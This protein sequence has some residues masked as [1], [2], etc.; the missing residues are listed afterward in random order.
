M[1]G[2]SL[3]VNAVK[4][5][6]GYLRLPKTEGKPDQALINKMVDKFLSSGGI[7]FDT[8]YVYDG[9]EAALRDTVVKRHPRGSFK[10]ATKLQIDVAGPEMSM[11]DIF[12][13]SLERLGTDYIDSYLIHGINAKSNQKAEKLGAW[14]HLLKLKAQGL[15][16]HMGFSFHGPPEDLDEILQKHPEAEFVQL[17]I[18]YFDWDNPKVQSRRLYE[19]ARA[20]N[21]PIIV[22]EPLLG[23]KLASTDSPAAELFFKADPGAS[24]ASW[25]LRF[26]AG[27]DGVIMV[28]SGMSSYEQMTD[29]IATFTNLSPLTEDE[30]SIIDKAAG[31]LRSV[32]RVGCTQCNYCKDCPSNIHIPM[33]IDIYNDFLIH[34]TMTNLDRFYYLATAGSGKALDCTAC[35]ACE[36]ICPQNL[37]IVD[38][39]TN[40]S[41]MFD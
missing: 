9:A 23:G 5:G 28:L 6:F 39:M 7:Y 1:T 4:L 29:N 32:P 20:H 41:K 35:R 3:S 19:T 11:D 34:K 12:N 16:G 40:I 22:M 17:Q 38:T 37:E 26:A 8:A 36:R 2:L 31:I 30:R 25:G 14:D 18:N 33:L 24:P 10:I 27:L 13:T 15:I 21:K